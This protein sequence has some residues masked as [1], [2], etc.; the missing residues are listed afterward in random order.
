[1]HRII[2]TCDH[3]GKEIDKIRDYTDMEIRD[4]ADY[5]ETDLCARCYDELSDMVLQYINKKKDA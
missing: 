1:M 5:I 3:C 2:Y 4:F